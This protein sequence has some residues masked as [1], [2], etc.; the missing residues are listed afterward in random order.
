MNRTHRLGVQMLAAGLALAACAHA[1]RVPE[2][3]AP[4]GPPLLRV[5]AE[6]ADEAL[7]V[8]QQLK[9]RPVRA[10]GRTLYFE[11][12]AD[13]ERL[14]REAGF[15]PAA[16]DPE[17]GAAQ[18]VVVRRKGAEKRLADAGARVLLREPGYWIVRV[19]PA[20]RRTLARLGYRVEPL[21]DREPHPRQVRVAA[22]D[23][24]QVR[25]VVA[26]HVDVFHVERGEKGLVVRGAAFDDA[27]DALRAL[28]L[29]V[30]V[31]PDPPGVTR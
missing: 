22:A 18:V 20:Q 24:D 7:L 26:R 16:A 29:A 13:A 21:G 2:E 25:D 4:A 3:P 31:L 12:T 5:E 9:I 30:E 8:E 15:E 11:R 6:D 23:A 10:S 28:G 27:I 1:E 17:E 19:S 14:L